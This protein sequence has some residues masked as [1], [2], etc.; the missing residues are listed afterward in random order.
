[1]SVTVE[2]DQATTEALV[3]KFNR[4]NDE[5]EAALADPRVFLGH[6]RATDQRT[7]EQFL[8]DFSEESGWAWQG[9]ILDQFREH[10]VTLAL[11]A[12][13]LG[14][15]WIAIGYALWK[16]VSTPGTKALA[17]SINEADAGILINRAWD[18][19]ESLPEHLRYGVKVLKPHTGRPVDA[20]RVGAPG[21]QGLRAGR[22]ARDA[23]R[24]PRPGRDA[25][26]AR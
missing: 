6:T 18:L 12:R 5:R 24:R 17:V 9:E 16:I 22:D 1:M 26:A 23:A 21:R 7:G 10:Q 8:F 13:Q 15:S 14:I 20:D 3:E 19:W 4:L 25:G 2:A 11:K